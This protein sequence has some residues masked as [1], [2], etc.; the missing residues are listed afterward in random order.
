MSNVKE[1]YDQHLGRIYE[2]M[3]GDFDKAAHASLD[4][5]KRAG[6]QP[7]SDGR[8]VDLGCGH[9]LQSIP[10]ADAG[11]RALA[12]DACQHLLDSLAKRAKGKQIEIAHG[13]I[14]DFGS[15]IDGEVELIVC[16]GDTLT[17]LESKESVASVLQKAAESLCV[18]GCLCLS[19]RDY[20]QE[21]LLDVSRFI[22]VKSSA[23]RIH[24]CFLEDCDTTVRVTDLVHSY[25]N[26]AWRLSASSYMKVKISPDLVKRTAGECG[27]K[28]TVEYVDRGMIYLAF[29]R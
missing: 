14:E 29:R 6:I 26:E 18:G 1:H 7:I 11:F 4:F 10:I 27:L 22:P 20:T 16:M 5:F 13:S 25:E 12:I 9:G 15:L 17:H 2:W 3:V 23:D 19:F 21:P 8:A 24:T 28:L